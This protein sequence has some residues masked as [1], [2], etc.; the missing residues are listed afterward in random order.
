MKIT[1]VVRKHA[2]EQCIAEEEELKRHGSE[3]EG[4]RGK[5]R[6]RLQGLNFRRVARDKK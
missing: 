6:R 1:E 4:V 3:V 5:G 2:A